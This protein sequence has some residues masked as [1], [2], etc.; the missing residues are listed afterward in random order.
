MLRS[1]W[2]TYFVEREIKDIMCGISASS[3]LVNSLLWG[4]FVLRI[5]GRMKP[6]ITFVLSLCGIGVFFV[7]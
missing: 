7:F 1:T 5:P 4:L 2:L 6:V 3:V